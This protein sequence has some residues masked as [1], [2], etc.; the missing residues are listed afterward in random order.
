M[1]NLK[2][3]SF[4]V[5]IPT[6]GSAVRLRAE[7]TLAYSVVIRAGRDNSGAVFIGDNTGTAIEWQY[8]L[9]ME[10]YAVRVLYTL[11]INE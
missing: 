1:P 10:T 2:L 9:P 11:R 5:T 7:A 4:T 3:P 6:P 8:L